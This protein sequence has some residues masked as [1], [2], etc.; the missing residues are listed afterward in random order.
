MEEDP[1]CEHHL[2]WND[3]PETILIIKKI[4]DKEV[5]EKFVQLCSY[6]LSVSA[7]CMCVHVCVCMC[8][9]V[10]VHVCACVCTCVC[11]C[12]CM[13]ACVCACACVCVCVCVCVCALVGVNITCHMI[14]V[15][16]I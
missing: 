10:C 15:S 4:G 11:M 12:V 1:S 6:L 13:R 16:V 8:V 3:Y 7:V 2:T 9:Y 5:T 14:S